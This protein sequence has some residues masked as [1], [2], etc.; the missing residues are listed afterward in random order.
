MA[1]Y[2]P[3]LTD[4]KNVS[5]S[6]TEISLSFSQIENILG[7]KLPE[8]SIHHSA[9]WSNEVDGQHVQAHSWMDAG[10]RVVDL[11]QARKWVKFTRC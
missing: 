11:D 10:W 2:Y 8:S 1:K 6:Q 7:S 5:S 3:L 9:W 4:F